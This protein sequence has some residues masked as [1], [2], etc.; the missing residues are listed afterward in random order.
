ML[1]GLSSIVVKHRDSTAH[2]FSKGKP[3]TGGC[4]N[5]FRNQILI[6]LVTLNSV[7]MSVTNKIEVIKGDITKH[8][9]GRYCKM[10]LTTSLLGGGGVD[11]AIHRAGGS[12]NTGRLQEDYCT[13]GRM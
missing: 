6:L 4:F 1:S 11:G 8:R 9:G 3:F 13:T 10:R 2:S 12:G 7:R 5:Y